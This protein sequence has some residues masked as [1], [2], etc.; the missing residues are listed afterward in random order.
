MTFIFLSEK[1]IPIKQIFLIPLD[2]NSVIY[3]DAFIWNNASSEYFLT[4][5]HH[6]I[7]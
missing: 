7:Q 2:F 1:E 6:R 4:L 5:I 3:F